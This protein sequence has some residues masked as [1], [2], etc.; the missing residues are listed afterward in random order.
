MCRDRAWSALRGSPLPQQRGRCAS[1]RWRWR[2]RWRAAGVSVGLRGEGQSF[3]GQ[4]A[5]RAGVEAGE[6]SP[7]GEPAQIWGHSFGRDPK[8]AWPGAQRPACLSLAGEHRGAPRGGEHPREEGGPDLRHDGQGE[9]RVRLVLDRGGKA[10]GRGW[11]PWAAVGGPCRPS[12]M[13]SRSMQARVLRKLSQH[14][15]PQPGFLTV[16]T[17]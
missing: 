14:F 12:E 10:W 16:F 7:H 2:W 5:E 11:R 15:F 1:V 13:Q 8:A 4:E 9:L 6:S 17:S 3:P